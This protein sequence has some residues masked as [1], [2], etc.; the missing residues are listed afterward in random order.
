MVDIATCCILEI[1][2]IGPDLERRAPVIEKVIPLSLPVVRDSAGDSIRDSMNES[3]VGELKHVA[4]ASPPVLDA[5]NW[6]TPR[7]RAGCPCYLDRSPDSG[8]AVSLPPEGIDGSM[9]PC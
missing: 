9:I 4:G 8:D 5:G 7:P 2:T 1:V 3:A 6:R